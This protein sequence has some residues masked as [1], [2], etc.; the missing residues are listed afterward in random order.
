MSL[1]AERQEALGIA[2]YDVQVELARRNLSDYFKLS[3][4]LNPAPHQTLIL[5]AVAEFL[6]SCWSSPPAEQDKLRVLVI[7][8]PPGAGK[9]AIISATLPA[10]ILGNR[11]FERIGIISAQG[12]LSGLFENTIRGDIEEGEVYRDCFPQWEARPDKKRGW[13]KG[14]LYLN[15]LPRREATPSV[16][17]AGL[18][19]SV[20]GRRYTM[21]V[22]D[23][24]QDQM[25]TMTQ[26]QRDRSWAF[27]DGTVLSR[28]IPGSPVICV[29]QRWHEDDVSGRLLKLYS[30]KQIS[31]PALRGGESY[32]PS[33][34]SIGY[35][36]QRRLSNPHLFQANYQQEP[37]A[38]DGAIFKRPDFHYY[39]TASTGDFL[40][41]SEK[42]IKPSQLL[43]Y[44]SWDTAFKKGAENDYNAMV[45]IAVNQENNDIFV[46][47][48][49]WERLE[50]PELIKQ[51]SL[52]YAAR[53]P[54]GGVL[55]E[56]K[57]SGS[58]VVQMLK[59][60]SDVPVIPIPV[61]K[62]K[63]NRAKATTG[64]LEAGKIH[65]PRH[66]PRIAEF[67]SFLTSFPFSTHDDPVDAFS[68]AI[69][70]VIVNTGLGV[71]YGF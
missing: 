6:E 18:F 68:Q 3:R 63:V 23:D 57:A 28:T 27:L 50:F 22:L 32:W 7:N 1:G 59:A 67:E 31:I 11:P 41:P 51:M 64:Y 62:D 54:A 40:L 46:T 9:S 66:H 53:M 52:F 44:Q 30:P 65:F 33:M 60:Q 61:E 36:E 39:T 26:D 13:S 21:L 42:L 20:I 2:L 43:Y 24:P 69:N 47:D 17:S 16:M 8:L 49:Y 34:Y 56:D 5:E 25:T 15:G 29:Q 70:H 10:W 12:T 4:G 35:L 55:V 71:R 19:G 48:V 14:S 45:E 38:G 37:G 58:S